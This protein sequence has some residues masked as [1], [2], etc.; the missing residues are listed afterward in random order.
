LQHEEKCPAVETT[1]RAL[2]RKWGA[3]TVHK[4]YGLKQAVAIFRGFLM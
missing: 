3:L 2:G 4:I 1:L